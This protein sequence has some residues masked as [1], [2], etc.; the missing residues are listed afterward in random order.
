MSRYIV[1]GGA[2]FIG[3]HI[4]ETLVGQGHEVVVLDDLSTGYEHN[5]AAFRDKIEFIKGSITDE[6]LLQKIMPGTD[7]VFHQG[8]LASVPR[9]VAEP[10]ASNEV[11]ITGTLKVFI[12]AKEAGVRR[13][14]Y[15]ASSSAYG[16]SETLPKREDMPGKPLSPYAVT[17]YVDELYGKVFTDIYDLPTVGLRYFNVFGPRQDPKSQYAAVIPLFITRYLAGEVPLIHGDGGQSRDFTFIE[18]VVQANLKAA[19]ADDKA[20]GLVYNVACGAK[21]DLVEL[22]ERIRVLTGSES[23]PE[24]GPDRVGDVR[25]SLADISLA[26]ERLGYDPQVDLAE[27]LERTVRWYQEQAG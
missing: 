4:T 11:N 22:A 27:G 19:A 8:A 21:I 26:Q 16:D 9:S 6:A 14:V 5:L 18:N 25:H 15:A 10:L 12:A 13:V 24:H 1:T 2:G 20:D 17:K 3:S 7:V 23:H